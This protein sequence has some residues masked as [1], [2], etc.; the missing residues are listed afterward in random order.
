MKIISIS[1][2]NFK[3][4]HCPISSRDIIFNDDELSSSFLDSDQ[5]VQETCVEALLTS[6]VP[7]VIISNNSLFESSWLSFVDATES[8]DEDINLTEALDS[9]RYDDF[10]C[11]QVSHYG[12]ASGPVTYQNYYI[13]SESTWG[14]CRLIP[15]D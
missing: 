1:T 3:G 8:D 4:F 2:L 13:I 7:E 14:D 10:I 15:T 6:L 12:I 9:F 11:L 5:I